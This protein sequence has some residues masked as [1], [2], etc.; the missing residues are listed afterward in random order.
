MMSARIMY[1]K[2]KSHSLT[3]ALF[4]YVTLCGGTRIRDRERTDQLDRYR[5]VQYN[6]RTRLSVDCCIQYGG[7]A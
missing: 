7:Q 1:I 3:G 6:D 2:L 5:N 4:N